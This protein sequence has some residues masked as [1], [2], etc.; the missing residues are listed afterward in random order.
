MILIVPVTI[1]IRECSK[2]NFEYIYQ[3]ND[4][5]QIQINR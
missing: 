4:L 5:Y 1:S 3:K 2:E